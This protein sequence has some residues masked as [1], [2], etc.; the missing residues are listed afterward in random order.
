MGMG[1]SRYGCRWAKI[2]LRVTHDH[3]YWEVVDMPNGVNVVGLK[4]VF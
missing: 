3:H 4:W 1:F 2:C